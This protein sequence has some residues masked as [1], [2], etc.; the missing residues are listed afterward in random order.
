M[1]SKTL[2]RQHEV[3]LG[4]R[5]SVLLEELQPYFDRMDEQLV[6]AFKMCRLTDEHALKAIK[7]QMHSLNSLKLN[8]GNVIE[9]GELAAH[10]LKE[11]EDE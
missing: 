2:D 1:D 7:Q 6:I 9:T 5:A 4:H 11:S 10:T 8:I 3:E